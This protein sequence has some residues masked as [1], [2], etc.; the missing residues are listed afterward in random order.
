MR[1]VESLSWHNSNYNVNNYYMKILNSLC[2]SDHNSDINF[3]SDLFWLD[4]YHKHIGV[5]VYFNYMKQLMV[6]MVE[7]QPD[8]KVIASSKNLLSV[9]YNKGEYQGDIQTPGCLEKTRTSNFVFVGKSAKFWQFLSLQT[10]YSFAV[11]SL[12]SET[13]L[14]SKWRHII[15]CPLYQQREIFKFQFFL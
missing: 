13:T 5:R 7:S 14:Y 12:S 11:S 3:N 1:L 10:F 4:V 15:S 2:I 6:T 9:Y 8:N